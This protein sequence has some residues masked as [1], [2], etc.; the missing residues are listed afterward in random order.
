MKSVALKQNING[1]RKY[2][3]SAHHVFFLFFTDICL[4]KEASE[5]T[6]YKAINTRELGSKHNYKG[7]TKFNNEKNSYG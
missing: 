7:T 6:K 5:F 3:K 4:E 2:V 1:V